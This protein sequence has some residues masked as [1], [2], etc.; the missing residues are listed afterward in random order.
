MQAGPVEVGT[1]R[2]GVATKGQSKAFGQRR[3]IREKHRDSMD[4]T[5]Y[6]KRHAVSGQ[7]L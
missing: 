5:V 3:W 4:G 1:R 6:G 2:N 7:R